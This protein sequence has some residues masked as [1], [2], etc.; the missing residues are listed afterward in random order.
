MEYGLGL[1]NRLLVCGSFE[2]KEFIAGSEYL[3]VVIDHPGCVTI[4]SVELCYGGAIEM[5]ATLFV[6]RHAN[7]PL[8][9]SIDNWWVVDERGQRWEIFSEDLPN[10]SV[11]YG[12]GKDCGTGVFVLESSQD[13]SHGLEFQGEIHD[14]PVGIF[15]VPCEV[16]FSSPSNSEPK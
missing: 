15:G 5:K 3:V 10:F 9:G 13:L 14:T 1:G 2:K 7:G 11:Q 12:E 16:E 6:T 8:A 4:L